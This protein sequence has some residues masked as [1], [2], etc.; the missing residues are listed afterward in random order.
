MGGLWRVLT[1]YVNY[2]VMG[3]LWRV[4]TSWVDYDVM[5]G[6]TPC[7]DYDITCGLW[8]HHV[9]LISSMPS[10]ST[11]TNVRDTEKC[12]RK[13]VQV[14]SLCGLSNSSR[15]KCNLSQTTRH[16]YPQLYTFTH[17]HIWSATDQTT[18]SPRN[19]V[20]FQITISLQSEVFFQ[21][22]KKNWKFSYLLCRIRYFE[23]RRRSIG[24]W[25]EDLPV[26]FDEGCVEPEV[27]RTFVITDRYRSLKHTQHFLYSTL[28]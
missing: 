1:S 17:I 19:G 16:N 9:M 11:E 5:G 10:S 7:V 24:Y 27:E 21:K 22:L 20:L 15:V 6:L 25:R 23:T 4:M 12:S 3:G 8:R 26:A 2:D 14:F 18:N 28:S 13:T